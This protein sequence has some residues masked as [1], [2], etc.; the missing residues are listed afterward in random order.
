MTLVTLLRRPA[1]RGVTVLSVLAAIG[2]G[3]IAY[4]FWA[5]LGAVTNLSDGYP[6]GFWIGII[7]IA[8]PPGLWSPGRCTSSAG[9][10]CALSRPAISPPS[11]LPPLHVRPGGSARRRQI[12]INW[13]HGSPIS[14]A[15][16][17][18]FYT[19]V[20]ALSSPRRARDGSATA[21]LPRRRAVRH[22]GGAVAHLTR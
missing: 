4:R 8:S 10:G 15:W 16:C 5:G 2:L 18:M 9:T 6:W 12:L 7:L 21:R 13:N 1:T 17:V 11:Q 20:L 3:L 14:V 19:T 22:R